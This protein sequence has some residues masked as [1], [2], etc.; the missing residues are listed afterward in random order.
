M[1]NFVSAP[2]KKLLSQY[3]Y[4]FHKE[5]LSL[6]IL[7]GNFRIDNLIINDQEINKILK[8]KGLPYKLKFGLLK[9]FEM[10]LSLIGT[11]VEKLEIEDL[12]LIAGPERVEDSKVQG[13]EEDNMYKLVINNLAKE[14]KKQRTLQTIN[15]TGLFKDLETEFATKRAAKEQEGKP[16]EAKKKGIDFLSIELLEI[17]KHFL[18]VDIAIKNITLIYE[19]NLEF[20][21]TKESLETFI[22]IVNF[23]EFRFKSGDVVQQTDSHGVFKNFFNIQSFLEKSGTWS[24][25]R[26]ACW[27]FTIDNISISFSAG[28]PL[29][30]N[31]VENNSTLDSN[32]IGMILK[33]FYENLK[34]D[35]MQNSFDLLSLKKITSDIVLFYKDSSKIPVN[36]VFVLF[37]FSQ[38]VF[39]AEINKIS[40]LLDV[41]AF[42][43]NISTIKQ[44][45]LVKPKFRILTPSAF[46]AV[47]KRLKLNVEDTGLLTRFNK[48]VIQEYIQESLYL[49][50]YSA[51][52]SEGIETD[53]ARLLV[54]K[55]FC[56]QSRIYKLI[57]GDTY[58]DFINKEIDERQ[59]KI[60]EKREAKSSAEKLGD[61]NR[62]LLSKEK[63]PESSTVL[64]LKRI[65][66]HVRV[67]FNA[68]LHLL[69]ENTMT[70]EQSMQINTAIID[71]LNP[72][73]HTRA[74]VHLNISSIIF[75]FSKEVYPVIKK[76]KMGIFAP[77]VN[78]SRIEVDATSSN[79]LEL[80][81][82]GLSAEISLDQNKEG[83][84]VYFIYVNSQLGPLVCNYMPNVFKGLAKTL[85]QMNWAF[86]RNF[87][88]KLAKEVDRNIQ[89][90][91][92]GKFYSQKQNVNLA[93]KNAAFE[94]KVS[95]LE[96]D[97]E[98]YTKFSQKRFKH[99]YDSKKS[100]SFKSVHHTVKKSNVVIDFAHT[101][102]KKKEEMEAMAKKY[103]SVRVDSKKNLEETE[104]DSK[105]KQT[106]LL[107]R[108]LTKLFST[109]VIQLTLKI[110][111]LHLNVF[112]E[113]FNE[114]L[115]LR[116]DEEEIRIDIDLAFKEVT[117]VKAFGL[118][119]QS[120]RSLMAL[121]ALMERVLKTM[122]E[123]QS[124]QKLSL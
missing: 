34:A 124:Y 77:K 7:R 36:A 67:Q 5:Q 33:R 57:F 43:K 26:A 59:S 72:A 50:R 15:P 6:Q 46:N 16:Q 23:K 98:T 4:N 10:K 79:T 13:T 14:S 45:A 75:N 71:V 120:K 114:A 24:E 73:A 115:T 21:Y 56:E 68:R 104:M 35:K 111:P 54:I 40:I 29:F 103:S 96:K 60:T 42:F 123:I 85:I 70:P 1:G 90:L 19:D 3:T 65:H 86:S 82:F 74:K 20:I 37:D 64:V 83:D 58:P 47:C 48:Y 27:N 101:E 100:I 117:T 88:Y 109:L 38:I 106:E 81:S 89:Q 53:L 63:L 97:S 17:I 18:D 92:F 11:K 51:Y 119:L 105:K 55:T 113:D 66:I 12:I 102:K 78:N 93:F 52:L 76:S 25:T 44:I 62:K 116:Y 99:L 108:N 110:K 28:N 41:L 87:R 122:E 49:I 32:K 112:D 118:E 91:Q 9:K 80:K 39:N 22:T 61:A 2:I 31:N 121:R 84:N 95:R 107:F 69:S 94:Q 8:E 30:V